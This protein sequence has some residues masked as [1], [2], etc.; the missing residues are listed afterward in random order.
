MS[1]LQQLN[2][3]KL[4]QRQLYSSRSFFMRTVTVFSITQTI[5]YDPTFQIS[6][7]EWPLFWRYPFYSLSQSGTGREKGIFMV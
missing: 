3:R 6:S 1:I 5:Q 7:S 4:Y 2:Y